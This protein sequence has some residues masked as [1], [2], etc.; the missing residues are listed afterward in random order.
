MVNFINASILLQVIFRSAVEVHI[1]S[2]DFYLF[3]LQQF[4]LLLPSQNNLDS[5]LGR[6]V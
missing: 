5:L 1:A 6:T 3:L 4:I 2:N